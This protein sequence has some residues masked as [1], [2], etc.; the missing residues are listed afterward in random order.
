MATKNIRA[1]P[2]Q[3]SM[4]NCDSY[5]VKNVSYADN[6]RL[7]TL[8]VPYYDK[9]YAGQFVHIRIDDSVDPLLRRPFSIYDVRYNSDALTNIDLGFTIVGRGTDILSKKTPLDKVGFLGPLGNRFTINKTADVAVF[10]AGGIGIT[11][12]YFL[13][14]QYKEAKTQTKLVLLFGARSKEELY[15]LEEF[16]G[17]GINIEVSTD[18]GSFGRKGFVTLL[19]EDY[20]R[21]NKKKNIQIYSCGPTPMMRRVAEI[22]KRED[23]PCELSLEKLMGCAL[24]ACGAC[25]TKV[26]GNNGDFRYSRICIEGPVYNVNVL[27]SD[28]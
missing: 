7:I 10:V 27:T 25:V 22:A 1:E 3:Q 14:K 12:F 21:K 28:F 13:T 26:V 8:A 16:E 17:L 18:D 20:L 19:L 11:P 4:I 9:I 24:G 5:V 2:R 6:C 23:V 15:Y